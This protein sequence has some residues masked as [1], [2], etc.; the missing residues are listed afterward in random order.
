MPSPDLVAE[1]NSL[2]RSESEARR[3]KAFDAMRSALSAAERAFLDDA[4]QKTIVGDDVI[5]HLD[6]Q[7]VGS[8]LEK[9]RAAL[10][11][12]EKAGK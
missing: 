11:L 1:Q 8:A 12:A 4:A 7:S 9:V 2:G 6:G 10:A 3:D 5:Y